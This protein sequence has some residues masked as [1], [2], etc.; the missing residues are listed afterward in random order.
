MSAPLRASAPGAASALIP[1]RQPFIHQHAT[2]ALPAARQYAQLAA[3]TVFVPVGRLDA[4]RAIIDQC[5]QPAGRLRAQLRLL[6][7]AGLAD[8]GGVD[9]G[10]ADFGAAIIDRV[11]I[12]D[13][14]GARA[15]C[16]NGKG[17]AFTV[18]LIWT[19][20]RG[21]RCRCGGLCR[22]ADGAA[23][24]MPTTQRAQHHHKDN[25]GAKASRGSGRRAQSHAPRPRKARCSFQFSTTLAA[26]KRQY[27]GWITG[28][29]LCY[30]DAAA[31]SIAAPDGLIRFGPCGGQIARFWMENAGVQGG[32]DGNPRLL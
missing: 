4:E 12:D 32:G 9:I 27:T 17:G 8:F 28:G 24:Q 13:A 10:D 20:Q 1:A 6:R 19:Q 31:A 3:E 21:G 25:E 29:A 23:C 18:I 26:R 14:I 11:T 22:A 7:A 2:Q 30:A 15:R 5:L 16:A